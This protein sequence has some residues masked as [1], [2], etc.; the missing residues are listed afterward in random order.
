MKRT[1]NF[2]K[3]VISHHLFT[4]A[5]GFFF[6]FWGSLLLAGGDLAVLHPD[7]TTKPFL[8]DTHHPMF[9]GWA[10]FIFGLL[11]IFL[12]VLEVVKY[13]WGHLHKPPPNNTDLD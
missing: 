13:F 12:L 7:G 6:F 3:N 9:L 10:F 1:V 11:F 8:Q 2:I 4:F 5:T